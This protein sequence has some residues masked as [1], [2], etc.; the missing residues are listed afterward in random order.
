MIYSMIENL[1]P[2]LSIGLT[3]ARIGNFIYFYL[4]AR[5]YYAISYF[6]RNLLIT[7]IYF[8]PVIAI[9]DFNFSYLI[10]LQCPH[11]L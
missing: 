7:G 6:R 1:S 2:K 3:S 8:Y 4:G 5:R 10:V 9:V 11:T